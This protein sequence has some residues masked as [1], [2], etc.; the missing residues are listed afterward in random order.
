MPLNLSFSGQAKGKKEI[1][2]ILTAGPKKSSWK[3]FL[4]KYLSK[5]ESLPA[6]YNPTGTYLRHLDYEERDIW[7]TQFPAAAAIRETSISKDLPTDILLKTVREWTIKK[8]I[9]VLENYQ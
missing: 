4:K 3:V 9:N 7:Y 1:K 5:V 8:V 6:P 2:Q